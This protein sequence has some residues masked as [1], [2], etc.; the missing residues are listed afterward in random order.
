MRRIVGACALMT[1][2][3]VSCGLFG[4]AGSGVPGTRTVDVGAEIRRI[5]IGDGFEAEIRVGTN[6][7]RE[8]TVTIDDNLLGFLRVSQDGDTLRVDLDGRVRD[9][10]LRATIGVTALGSL[11]ADGASRVTVRG[12][13]TGDV[14]L[15]VSGASTIQ[16]VT[17]DADTLEADVGGASALEAS[18]TAQ[19][20]E[21]DVSGASE[22][23]LSELEADTARIDASGASSVDVWVRDELDATASGASTVVYRGEPS[24]IR[25]DSSGSSTVERA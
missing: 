23:D 21:A 18:G 8:A 2:V 25:I 12:S 11:S 7:S 6:V 1:L 4:E 17:L 16:G 14:R 5:E 20:I 22:L 3:S 10:T 24:D 9:A 13:L 15:Q 19:R